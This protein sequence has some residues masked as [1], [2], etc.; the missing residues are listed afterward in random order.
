MPWVEPAY[1]ENSK[2]KVPTGIGLK[3]LIVLLIGVACGMVVG[4]TSTKIHQPTVIECS[5]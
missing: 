4:V 2:P 5:E 3:C 1:E